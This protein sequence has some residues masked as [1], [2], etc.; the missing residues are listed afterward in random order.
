MEQGTKVTLANVTH[1]TRQEEEEEEEEEE[2]EPELFSL[3]FDLPLRRL[4]GEM[5]ADD[6]APSLSSLRTLWASTMP[7]HRLISSHLRSCH[8][9]LTLQE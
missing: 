6:L 3:N 2:S 4:N 7:P 9:S 8:K 1:A 5:A